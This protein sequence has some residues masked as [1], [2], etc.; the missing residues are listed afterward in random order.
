M[1]IIIAGDGMVGSTLARRLSAEG[2]NLTMIDSDPNVLETSMERY[3]AIAVHGNCASMSGKPLR[4]SR[5][6]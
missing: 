2:Y 1:N 5:N 3:D 4:A 6:P